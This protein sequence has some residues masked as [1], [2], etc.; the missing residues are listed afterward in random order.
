MHCDFIKS[1]VKNIFD[2]FLESLNKYGSLK[3][4]GVGMP[5]EKHGSK[6]KCGI[7]EFWFSNRTP[8]L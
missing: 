5:T 8:F 6:F 3:T 7:Y 1:S 4:P 2:L